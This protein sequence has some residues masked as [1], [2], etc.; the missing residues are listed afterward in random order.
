MHVVDKKARAERRERPLAAIF[1]D[2]KAVRSRLLLCAG[3]GGCSSCGVFLRHLEVHS[4]AHVGY[5]LARE[6]FDRGGCARTCQRRG[7]VREGKVDSRKATKA[8]E[9]ILSHSAVAAAAVSADHRFELAT[10]GSWASLPKP[11]RFFGG[12]AACSTLA[13]RSAA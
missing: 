11:L 5:A 10:A 9:Q 7:P 1:R 2:S 8:T 13:T 12:M 3:G 4:V 6:G